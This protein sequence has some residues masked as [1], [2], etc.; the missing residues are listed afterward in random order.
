MKSKHSPKVFK[1][2]ACLRESRTEGFEIS[3]QIEAE[4]IFFREKN[5]CKKSIYSNSK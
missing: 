4:K 2:V 1:I 5:L 3:Y